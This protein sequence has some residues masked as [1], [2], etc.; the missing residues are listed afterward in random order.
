M[1]SPFWNAVPLGATTISPWQ[2]DGVI[3]SPTTCSTGSASI[4]TSTATAATMTSALMV[5]SRVLR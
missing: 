2:M 4:D 1:T 5:L 3:D